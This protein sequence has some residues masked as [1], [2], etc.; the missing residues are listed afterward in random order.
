MESNL[1]SDDSRWLQMILKSVKSDD[2]TDSAWLQMTSSDFDWV[3]LISTDS[4]E[5]Q[6]AFESVKSDDVKWLQLTPTNFKWFP[7]VRN[8]LESLP[9]PPCKEAVD[10]TAWG[11]AFYAE[12]MACELSAYAGH[13]QTLVR[14]KPGKRHHYNF[15]KYWF[16]K[17]R[18]GLAV[19]APLWRQH[20]DHPSGL[21]DT[22]RSW[23]CSGPHI[24]IWLPCTL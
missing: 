10:E 17:N 2:F 20:N 12:T 9:L 23:T 21:G 14:G 19:L 11:H 7:K 1:T 15:L 3:Q 22:H 24:T 4:N 6:L 18:Y 8:W 5:L 13:G 16:S